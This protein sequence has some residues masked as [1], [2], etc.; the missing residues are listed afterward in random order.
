MNWIALLRGLSWIIAYQV[1][2]QVG[3]G[4]TTIGWQDKSG[5]QVAIQAIDIACLSP[6]RMAGSRAAP[7]QKENDFNDVSGTVRPFH[8]SDWRR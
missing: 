7:G 2:E 3:Q 8:P 5:S 1:R 4:G 6:C